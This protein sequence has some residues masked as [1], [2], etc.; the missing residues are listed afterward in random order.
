[1]N[2][3]SK[4][5][6]FAKINLALNIVGKSLLIHKIESIISFL[7]LS[8]E[9]L[10]KETHKKRHVIKFTGKFSKNIG[11]IS[12]VSE[13]LRI[14]DKKKLLKDKKYEIKI[15]KNIPTQA[16]LGG[17][18]MNAASV[19]KFLIKKQNITISQ[20]KILE[21]TNL[22][23][24]DVILGMYSKNLILKSNGSIHSISALESRNVLVIKPNFG[25]STKK[26]YSKVKKFNNSRFNNPNKK[27]FSY[28]KLKKMS[29]DLELIAFKIYP[30]LKILKVFL[31]KLPNIK[32]VRMTGSGSAM[33]AYFS[34]SKLCK[35]AEKKV[36][37]HFRKYWCKTAKTM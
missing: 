32:L 11:K 35:Q 12:T 23:G 28:S 25:C 16:G 24:S 8:D 29:N 22:I 13:L 26:I 15:K 31:E 10:I 2:G 36:K 6:S 20:K 34:S 37:K 5:K 18:S 17:G 30:K 33:I 19:F 1:L 21:I 7:S 27:L 3:Y 4:I 14:L 9:M